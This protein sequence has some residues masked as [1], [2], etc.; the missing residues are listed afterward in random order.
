MASQEI[1]WLD[2]KL[3]G[4]MTDRWLNKRFGWLNKR[5]GCPCEEIILWGH[6]N[7]LS[8]CWVTSEPRRCYQNYQAVHRLQLYF[9]VWYFLCKNS[10]ILMIDYCDQHRFG[11]CSYIAGIRCMI[12]TY[13]TS[14]TYHI[15][16][17]FIG[18]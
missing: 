18:Q 4:Q 6:S 16:D 8:L 1:G 11:E 12:W 10:R 15:V 9:I 3:G 17:I 13:C 5:F 14:L 2:E 7:C